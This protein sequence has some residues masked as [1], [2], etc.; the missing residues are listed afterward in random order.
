MDYFQFLAT[1]AKINSNLTSV[2]EL[3]K[4]LKQSRENE[5]LDFYTA[6]CGVFAYYTLTT[7][8]HIAVAFKFKMDSIAY[9]TIHTYARGKLTKEDAKLICKFWDF[10]ERQSPDTLARVSKALGTDIND[11]T[12]DK[13]YIDPTSIIS[14]LLR[15]MDSANF[16]KRRS[17]GKLLTLKQLAESMTTEEATLINTIIATADFEISKA[18]QIQ[19]LTNLADHLGGLLKLTTK[20]REEL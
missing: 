5:N 17:V 18:E 1:N 16:G 20:T 8:R 4:I 19:I 13:F 11:V 6:L 14:D 7:V 3:R 2:A 9:P 12:S 15:D 10:T